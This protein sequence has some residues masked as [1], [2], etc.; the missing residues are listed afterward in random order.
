MVR[1]LRRQQRCFLKTKYFD[2]GIPRSKREHVI[3][4]IT[5]TSCGL[6][7]HTTRFARSYC[8]TSASI[9]MTKGKA[10]KGG[11]KVPNKALL[12]RVSY[13]YQAATYLA[14]Q[15]QLSK[16]ERTKSAT[17]T[18]FEDVQEA[19]EYDQPQ[20]PTTQA[21]SRRLLSD[22]RSVSM[23]AQVRMSPAM[24][25]SMCKYCDTMLVDGSSCSSGV[26][27]K[28]RG[29][30]KP[31][32]DVLVRNCKSCGMARRFPLTTGKQSKRPHSLPN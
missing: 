5:L 8:N 15:Q 30:K 18:S 25:H 12:S 1:V 19:P 7:L 16:S 17:W 31:W 29:G 6:T 24:K 2:D 9:V 22:L 27:N 21:I 10:S 23:K 20:D 14:T 13:L 28:S 11:G 26:E 4:L 3:F 32:A